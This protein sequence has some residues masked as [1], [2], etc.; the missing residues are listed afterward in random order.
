MEKGGRRHAV[1]SWAPHARWSSPSEVLPAESCRTPPFFKNGGRRG[2]PHIF[3]TRDLDGG[4]VPPPPPPRAGAAGRP[5]K[6]TRG[7]F[8]TQGRR[9]ADRGTRRPVGPRTVQ[10]S[11]NWLR[12]VFNWAV[13]WRLPNGGYL[14]RENPLRGYEAPRE[15]N[16]RRPVASDERVRAIRGVAGRVEM[17]VAWNG[18]EKVVPS[19]LPEV[20][21]LAVETGRRISAIL[22]L[23]YIRG[24]AAGSWTTR[25][26]PLEG[27]HRQERAGEHP[28]RQPDGAGRAGQRAAG[29]AWY[30]IGSALPVPGGRIQTDHAAP[31][32]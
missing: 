4:W 5:R 30:R 13:K 17:T 1:G 10:G 20:F 3:P 29:A 14:M 11:C 7:G 18:Q 26:N 12:W 28:A 31:G 27:R 8:D 15:L 16:P 23:R 32:G 24:P 9:V 2:P 21:D 25:I 19:H 6:R 22:D